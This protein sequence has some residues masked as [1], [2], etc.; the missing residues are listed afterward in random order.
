MSMKDNWG[1]YT[2]E[3]RDAAAL[4][5]GVY[6]EDVNELMES[7]GGEGEFIDPDIAVELWGDFS[8]HMDASWL[9][10]D[11]MTLGNFAAWLIEQWQKSEKERLKAVGEV[12]NLRGLQ[13][14]AGQVDH[15]SGAFDPNDRHEMGG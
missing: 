9:I 7:L 6:V 12:H 8:G 13:S 14:W 5:H 2:Q 4:K 10:Q 15:M 11:R 3:A 1:C